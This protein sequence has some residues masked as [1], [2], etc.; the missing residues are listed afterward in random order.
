VLEVIADSANERLAINAS[1][2]AQ[3]LNQHLA[4][5]ANY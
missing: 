3:T 2:S 5:L 4:G 1:T